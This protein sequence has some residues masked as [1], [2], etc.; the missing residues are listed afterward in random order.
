MTKRESLKQTI[1]LLRAAE[2]ADAD[3]DAWLLYEHV[4]G[5]SRSRFFLNADAPMPEEAADRLRS[6]TRRRASRVPVQHLIGEAWIDGRAFYVNE[7]VLIPR[8]D[9]ET[10]IRA[11]RAHLAPGMRVL[12][13]CT[14]SGCVLISLLVEQRLSGVGSDISPAALQVAG[15]N[16]ERHGVRADWL[17]GDLFEKV[18]GSFN[19]ITANPP[20]ITSEEIASLAPEVRDHDPRLALD[21]GADGLAILRPLIREA[22]AHLRPGGFLC[23]EIGDSQGAAVRR[24]FEQEGYR[25]IEVIR[26]IAGRDRVVTGRY[27]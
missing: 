21:G 20:Y 26:D 15:R 14:G 17:C 5:E 23:T 24:L 6:L 27:Q 18:E 7:D 9:T 22:R 2:I 16:A 10:L 11:A 8:Y 12:D 19:L 4:S 1:E 25:E 3:T 13:L